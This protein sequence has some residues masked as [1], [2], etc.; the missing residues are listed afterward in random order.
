MVV[1]P[2]GEF[3]MGSPAS[4]AGR[5]SDESPQ[6]R[7]RIARPFALGRFE[8]TFA[9]W[10]ACAAA[11]GC[12]GYRPEDRGW[13]R[14]QQPVINVSWNDAQGYVRWLSAN[15]VHLSLDAVH[16]R[17]SGLEIPFPYKPLSCAFSEARNLMLP[18]LGLARR[19]DRPISCQAR[20]NGSMPHGRGRR[21]RSGPGPRSRPGRRTTM[22]PLSMGWAARVT[23]ASGRWRQ[24]ACRQTPG[25]CTRCM[26]TCGNGWR[27]AITT[28]TRMLR[29]TDGRGSRMVARRGSCV[30]G[31]GAAFRG[32][33]APP[34]AA[35]ARPGSASSSRASGWPGCLPLE[36]LH[37][38]TGLTKW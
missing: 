35:G 22:A 37:P 31:R 24:A 23:I 14:G 16:F 15:A 26:G 17:S 11:G 34:S 2:A 38:H 13:G 28:A 7:V 20:R 27:T 21:R 6:H 12:G 33:C 19:P 32:T 10:D 30:A 29:R 4:E 18:V 36:L 9:E 3:M 25:G 5:D 1:V 8:V